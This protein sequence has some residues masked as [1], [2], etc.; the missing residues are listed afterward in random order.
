MSV[1]RWICRAPTVPWWPGASH[2]NILYLAA[3]G[4]FHRRVSHADTL[5]LHALLRRPLGKRLSL[6]CAYFEHLSQQGL[7]SQVKTT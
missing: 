4:H 1:I 6:C 5:D 2:W 3:Q 7:C